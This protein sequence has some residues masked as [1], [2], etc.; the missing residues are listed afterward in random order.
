[1]KGVINMKVLKEMFKG[2]S[3]KKFLLTVLCS[4]IISTFIGFTILFVDRSQSYMLFEVTSKADQNSDKMKE[5]GNDMQEEYDTMKEQ[6][7]EQ[8]KKYGE[9]YPAEGI[10]LYQMTNL[11]C[12]S[13]VCRIYTLTLLIGLILGILVYIIFVQNATGIQMLLETIFFGII[14][15]LLIL[16]INSGYNQIINW[17]I[18]EIGVSAEKGEYITHVYDI[19][20]SNVIY[21]FVG[22]VGVAY[23][24]NLIYQKIL[25]N[26]FNIKLSKT[27]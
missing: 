24:V 7:S 19:D 22:I 10:Y 4:V 8:K 18:N 13:S 26:K 11:L 25:V 3:I 14:I 9:D 2:F 5:I 15:V 6:F 17:L 12:S 27:K 20:S 23:V 21:I 16:L 1:M